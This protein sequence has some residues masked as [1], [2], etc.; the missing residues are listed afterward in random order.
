[1][2]E[3]AAAAAGAGSELLRLVDLFESIKQI[4]SL[5]FKLRLIAVNAIVTSRSQG[6][7]APGFD[8]VAGYMGMLSKELDAA[9]ARIAPDV[10]AW[11]SA[12]STLVK[13]ERT[14]RLLAQAHASEDTGRAEVALHDARRRERALRRS[15]LRHQRKVGATLDDVMQLSAGGCGAARSA[16]VEASYGGEHRLALGSV[17]GDF[18]V[19]ADSVYEAVFNLR[20]RAAAPLTLIDDDDDLFEANP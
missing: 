19:V 1:M 2:S 7:N 16:K 15:L 6:A 11:V 17:A 10:T 14:T 8:V 4:A 12:A 20:S 18:S 9:M 3:R 13:L 5:A